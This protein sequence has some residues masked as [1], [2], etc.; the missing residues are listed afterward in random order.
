MKFKKYYKFYFNN[1]DLNTK[2]IIIK[3]SFHY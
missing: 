3:Y 2:K 1:K